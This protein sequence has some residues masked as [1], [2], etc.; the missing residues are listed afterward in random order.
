MFDA[1][2]ESSWY[3]LR[4]PSH[5][6]A[7]RPGTRRSHRRMLPVDMY[8]GGREHA[9]R[10]HLYARFVTRA[11]HDLGLLP[12]A[13]PFPRLRLHGLLISRTARR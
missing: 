6:R 11:M 5:A 1:F 8:A 2:V 9:A 12:F 7:G 3:F 4:Y 10:H 13:E